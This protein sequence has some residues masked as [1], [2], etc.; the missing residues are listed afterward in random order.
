MKK[1]FSKILPLILGFG[2]LAMGVPLS[3]SPVLEFSKRNFLG[4]T[5]T[6]AEVAGFTT[7][8]SPSGSVEYLVN[9]SYEVENIRYEIIQSNGNKTP[10]FDEIR[11]VFYNPKNFNDATLGEYSILNLAVLIVPISGLI[12]L[13]FG[14]LNIKKSKTATK[15]FETE[16]END[17]IVAKNQLSEKKIFGTIVNVESVVLPNG[18]NY[19]IAIIQAKLPSG[20]IKQFRSEQIE[21]LT[22]GLLV[23]YQ[24]NPTPIAVSVSSGNI[25]DYYVNSEEIIS[26]IRKSFEAVRQ[27]N[28]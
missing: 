5:K 22:A 7:Q 15:K 21:G 6:K 11:T 8:T 18:I 25:D 4:W 24:A 28:L 9:F 3:I 1:G 16:T 23:G 19:G 26:A 13:I 14:I 2:M 20:E 27:I 17:S 12:L 10:S